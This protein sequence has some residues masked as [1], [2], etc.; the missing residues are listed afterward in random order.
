M[1]FDCIAVHQRWGESRHLENDF[2]VFL[3]YRK[4]LQWRASQL[5]NFPDFHFYI[6][7]SYSTYIDPFNIFI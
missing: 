4:Y 5:Q 7:I 1:K 2:K 3:D 6:P